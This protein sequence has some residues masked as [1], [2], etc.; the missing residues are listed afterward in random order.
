MEKFVTTLGDTKLEVETGKLA[1]LASGSVTLRMGD[2]V[3]LATAVMSPKP[4]EDVDFFPLLIDFEERMYAAGKIS[5]SRF[6]KREGRPSEEAILSAR[7]IDRPIR[8]LFPKGFY[9]DVQIVLTILS[10]DMVNDP[11]VLAIT[12]ASAALMQVGS[13]FQGPVAGVRVGYVDGKYI[14]NPTY[15]QREKSKLDLVVAGT[16]D[17]IMMVEAG[18]NE[19]SED[20]ILEGIEFGHKGMQPLITMQ[21]DMAKQMDVAQGQH[22]ISKTPKDLETQIFDDIKTAISDAV[23]HQDK[24]IR[25]AKMEE[26][27][28]RAIEKFATEETP[29]AVVAG[30]VNK[31]IGEEVRRNILEHD[32]RPDGR[33]PDEIRPLKMEVKLLPRTHG[34]AIFTRGETQ[35]LSTVTLGS[36]DDE[37]ILDTME[38]D[39]T[40]RYMH[41]YNFPPFATNEVRPMRSTNRREIGHGALA[42]RALLP[43]IPSRLDF[44]YTIR[45]VS[46]ILSSN[47]SSSMASVCG[48]T[49]SLMDAGVPIKKPIAGIAMGL[50][51]DGNKYKILTDIAGIEDFNG[52]MDFKVAGSRDGITAL[53]MDIKVAGITPQ[54][55]KDALAKAKTARYILLDEMAKVIAEPRKELSPYAPRVITVKVPVDKIGDVIGPGGKIINEI[56]EKAGGKA[57]TNISI[58]DD[59]STFI[60]STDAKLGEEAAQT[61]RQMVREIRPGERFTGK[62]VKITDFGAF[63]ELTPGHDGLVHI[64][65]LSNKRVNRVEDVVKEGDYLEVV[66]KEVDKMGR[67]N[68]SHK[69]TLNK[70]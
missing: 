28:A 18:A 62:V 36:L 70:K 55:M 8:P 64:S 19:V 66:V 37:Q 34:S 10:V 25:S 40:K 46:E 24:T 44:P 20:I 23:Y 67:I 52:D 32:R 57:V 11:D 58:E 1:V 59:G 9:N 4:R 38:Q 16:R 27:Q 31:I 49:L 69:D 14:L 60:T 22:E 45:V 30:I 3:I 39:T 43:V 47:G 2:T 50:I 17:A 12:A 53:Q 61:I 15:E 42:E 13:P 35:A 21:E 68:L 29:E 7:L 26:L 56:I 6:I 5:G 33:K 48:S 51:T 65:E 41:H 63:V 54:I